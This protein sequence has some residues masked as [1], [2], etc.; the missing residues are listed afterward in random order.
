MKKV[1]GKKC[2]FT[3]LTFCLLTQVAQSAASDQDQITALCRAAM[4]AKPD[5]VERLLQT[6]IDVNSSGALRCAACSGG[7]RHSIKTIRLLL[8]Y[9]AHVNQADSDGNTP[10]HK[11]Y[12]SSK[13]IHFLVANGANINQENNKGIPPLGYAVGLYERRTKTAEIFLEYGAHIDQTI[14]NEIIVAAP[15]LLP[16]AIA[17]SFMHNDSAIFKQFFSASGWRELQPAI[18]EELRKPRPHL[19]NH[20]IIG[21]L[22]I[23]HKMKKR[24]ITLPK[25]QP[26]EFSAQ[27]RAKRTRLLSIGYSKE[28]PTI[29]TTILAPWPKHDASNNTKHIKP[30][31]DSDAKS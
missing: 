11:A 26:I 12:G 18:N 4:Q 27:E 19:S 1:I 17:Y 5:E 3:F 13:I 31:N 23:L 30:D 2:T 16:T 20:S 6:G 29:E 28:E 25:I 21:H 9:G 7:L 14:A 22:T 10:L 24:G 15:S 8:N